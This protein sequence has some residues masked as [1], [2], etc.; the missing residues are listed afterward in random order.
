MAS[1]NSSGILLRRQFGCRRDRPSTKDRKMR[2]SISTIVMSATKGTSAI[3]IRE[4]NIAMEMSP[5]VM[6]MRDRPQENP[7]SPASLVEN[8]FSFNYS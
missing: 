1:E 5:K 3:S 2:T 7:S 4:M 8:D 6:R